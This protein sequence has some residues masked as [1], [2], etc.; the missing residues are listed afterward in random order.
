M[1][2]L[3]IIFVLLI[4]A[5]ILYSKNSAP[6][7]A[8][9]TPTA[10]NE[11][12][13]VNEKTYQTNLPT[14]IEIGAQ[15]C[16][17]CVLM[18]KVLAQLQKH[19]ADKMAIVFYDVEAPENETIIEKLAVKIIP[20]QIFTSAS[21]EI[22]FRHEGYFSL[23]E[24][25]TQWKKLGFEMGAIIDDDDE[26]FLQKLWQHGSERL[27]NFGA[28]ALIAAFIWGILSILLSPCHL[29]SIPLIIGF[30]DQQENTS[31]R[32]ACW[33]ATLFSSGILLTISALGL[34]TATLGRMAGDVG[35]WGNYIVAGVFLIVG[36]YLIGAIKLNFSG[37]TP[38][39]FKHHGALSAFILGLI[40]GIALGP[41][42]FAYMAPVLGVVFKLG[43]ENIFSAALLL[44]AYGIGHCS[45]IVLAGTFTE[46]VQR[47]IN[48]DRAGKH[49]DRVKFICGI[50][51]I[52]GGWWLLFTA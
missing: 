28:V 15:Q 32:R 49:V 39:K 20:L 26:N 47:L 46:K 41:C 11:N 27:N 48:S 13:T 51:V 44:F 7:I 38:K 4:A 5:G 52:F 1:K 43:A 42:T 37:A 31:P 3:L 8:I 22:L 34:I 18:K 25:I 35:S 6:S 14:L 9:K 24:I 19:Y 17:P 36:L 40:F 2:N 16:T 23:A 45:V 21:G 33:L 29:A 30:I 50:L 12:A 10:N